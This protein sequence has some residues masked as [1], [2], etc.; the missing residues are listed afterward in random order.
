LIYWFIGLLIELVEVSLLAPSRQSRN[1]E[2]DIK[3]L[4]AV[5]ATRENCHILLDPLLAYWRVV[6][7]LC[8]S[9]HLF[10]KCENVV[11]LHHIA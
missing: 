4:K 1:A 9:D 10:G 6:T 7:L 11:E 5:T 8:W 3:H 2:R